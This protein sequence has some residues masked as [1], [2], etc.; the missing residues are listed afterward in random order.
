MSNESSESN[1]RDAAR[2]HQLCSVQVVDGAQSTHSRAAEGMASF[3]TRDPI[4][5]GPST[6][7]VAALG[8]VPVDGARRVAGNAEPR[9]E[10]STRVCRDFRKD[11]RFHM[12]IAYLA[13]Q[14]IDS[15]LS[16]IASP[17]YIQY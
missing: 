7:T 6:G 2:C 13:V 3:T 8:T 10:P 1:G 12:N 15:V 9:R 11:K 4:D 5:F 14:R 16:P 17:A